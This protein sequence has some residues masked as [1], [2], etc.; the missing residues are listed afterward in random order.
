MSLH[1]NKA[2]LRALGIAE[3]FV[4]TM[5][6][7]ILAGVVMRADLR[8]DGLAYA[9]ASVGGNDATGAVL[10]IYQE[11]ARKDI[12][13]ILLE[14]AA[15][16]WFNIIDLAEVWQKTGKPLICLTY[17]DSPGLEQYIRDY[18]PGQEEKLQIYRNLGQRS[19]IRLK[20]GY[21]V[22][23]RSY[24]A[25]PEEARILLNKFTRDGRKPEPLRLASLAARAAHRKGWNRV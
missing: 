11:L 20:T 14:G 22:Y 3:S 6:H 16:S 5:R 1:L 23:V 15:I 24:G 13:A 10:A 25:D 7:S 4:R 19:A 12:N 18:F 2:G 9:Q 17:Q 21:V 8:V